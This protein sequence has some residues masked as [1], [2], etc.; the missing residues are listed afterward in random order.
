[1]IKSTE[2]VRVAKKFKRIFGLN[3]NEY[4]DPLM[5]GESETALE[6]AKFRAT[7]AMRHPESNNDGISLQDVVLEHYAND[8]V[9]LIKKI[10]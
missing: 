5:T 6:Y 9:E 4:I 8:G 7:M 1:M 3:L 10:I 2:Y